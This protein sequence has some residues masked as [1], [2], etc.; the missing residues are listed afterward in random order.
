[1]NLDFEDTPDPMLLVFTSISENSMGKGNERAQILQFSFCHSVF[2]S[3]CLSSL[4]QSVLQ[5]CLQS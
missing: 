4:L 5:S 2:L 3:F 1:M